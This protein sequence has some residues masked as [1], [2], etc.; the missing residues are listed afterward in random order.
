MNRIIFIALSLMLCLFSF[1]LK[2]QLTAPGADS[3][4]TRYGEDFHIFCATS[5]LEAN[6]EL[7]A[8]T[9]DGTNAD[10]TWQ[11][12]NPE[13][14]N[15]EY[16]SPTLTEDSLSSEIRNL[17]DGLY[18]V[19]ITTEDL[20]SEWQ[21]SWVLNNWI[22]VTETDI[23]DSTSTC[24]NFEV[25]ADFD[26]APLEVNSP[27]QGTISLRNQEKEEFFVEWTKDGELIR[28]Q[29]SPDV[30]TPVASET[31]VRYDLYIE[32]DFG[33]SAGDF[34]EYIS[35]IPESAF[36]ANPMEGEAVLEVEFA[37]NSINYDSTYWFFYK[38]NYLLSREYLQDSNEPVDSID[39]VLYEEQPIHEYKK[40]GEY[41]V[42]LVTV[43]ENETGNCRD[44]LYMEPGT[45]INVLPSLVEVPN[46]FT[47]NGDNM[48][49]EFV[50]KTQSLKSMSITIFN[51]W[52]GK[53]H[54]WKN[55]NII[56]SEDT[57]ALSVWDGEIGRQ[58]ASPGVY[59][60][61]IKYEGRDIDE[62]DE[63]GRPVEGKLTGFIHLFREKQ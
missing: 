27:T 38:D 60:Y 33:C 15:F 45:F 24:T 4:L 29:L 7:L 55:D 54:S 14:D 41:R 18:R 50:V 57:Y 44:T 12:Y 61:V 53:V 26:Y 2:A 47:P 48:N 21:E 46:F 52:G 9:I 6:G 40:S 32:D 1:S 11:K 23:P 22:R 42:K 39:F 62:E 37:N 13:S 49:D 35:K 10:F 59:Y 56:S 43:K 30:M 5:P 3:S 51:R 28:R 31:P 58:L 20:T 63:K 36:E 34:V 8:T 25:N 19:R 16:F 17:D